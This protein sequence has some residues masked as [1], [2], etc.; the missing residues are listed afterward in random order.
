MRFPQSC[1]ANARVQRQI[2]SA[3]PRREN[4]EMYRG[5][6]GN[7]THLHIWLAAAARS[8]QGRRWFLWRREEESK[9]LSQGEVMRFLR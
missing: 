3:A 8:P 6:R 4:P 2:R 1:S 9:E 5:R 7:G